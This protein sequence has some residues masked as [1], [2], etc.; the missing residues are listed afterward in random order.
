MIMW[1]RPIAALALASLLSVGCETVAPAPDL[2]TDFEAL[3]DTSD[4][5]L[6]YERGDCSTVFAL[7]NPQK[8]D[9][10]ERNELTFS[11]LLLNGFCHELEGDLEAAKLIYGRLL[12]EAPS[13]FAGRDAMERSRIIRINQSDPSHAAWMGN[14]H[15]RALAAQENLSPR[16]PI[17]RTTAEFPP[18]AHTTGIEGYAVVEFGI[19]PKGA[20][21]DPVVIESNPPLIFDGAAVRAIRRWVYTKR[22]KARSSDSQVIRLVFVG[23]G[24]IKPTPQ[25]SEA[26]EPG[27]ADAAEGDDGS[28]GDGE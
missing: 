21:S 28:D 9:S 26:V 7:A 16:E 12:D 27:A 24:P 13:S 22:T 19:T 11:M 23:D 10:W 20:T 6:A 5:Y 15:E 14:A 3:Q 17:E 8:L 4:A 2:P 1:I 25:A 18:V